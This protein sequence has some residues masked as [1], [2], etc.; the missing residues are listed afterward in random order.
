MFRAQT[1]P[2]PTVTARLPGPALRPVRR[3]PRRFGQARFFTLDNS[4][5]AIERSDDLR[6]FAQSFAAFFLFFSL[7]IA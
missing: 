5:V 3:D 1:A 7:L 2:V 4:D 6:L